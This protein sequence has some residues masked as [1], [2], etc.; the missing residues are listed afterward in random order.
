M[1]NMVTKIG[2][3]GAGPAGLVTALA[4]EAYCKSNKDVEITL[5]DKNQSAIDIC[6]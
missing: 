6:Y 4:L 1:L 5:I 3:I 2:I